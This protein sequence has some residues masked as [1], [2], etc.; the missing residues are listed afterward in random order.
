MVN[1]TVAR[2][3]L[4]VDRRPSAVTYPSDAFTFLP[5]GPRPARRVSRPPPPSSSPPAGEVSSEAR[6]RGHESP[7]EAGGD[8]IKKSVVSSGP[9]GIRLALVLERPPPVSGGGG[10]AVFGGDGGGGGDSVRV[11]APLQEG[12][13]PARRVSDPPPPSGT[14]PGVPG[15]DLSWPVCDHDADRLQLAHHQRC[16]HGSIH[17][18][19]TASLD[20]A[21]Q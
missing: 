20:L 13:R 18:H 9:D 12:S 15:G 7:P 17:R 11:L 21:G 1:D 5:G 14:P 2:R 6:R 8:A 4:P 10:A 3:P 16:G 19:G